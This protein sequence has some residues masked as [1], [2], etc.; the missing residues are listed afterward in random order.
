M[1][2]RGKY[3]AEKRQKELKKKKKRE[4]KLEKKKLKAMGNV[5]VDPETGE[6]VTAE[7]VDGVVEPAEDASE[8]TE[9]ESTETPGDDAPGDADRNA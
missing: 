5:V 6:E 9:S 2:K 7:A 4:E 1:A 3:G 8:A